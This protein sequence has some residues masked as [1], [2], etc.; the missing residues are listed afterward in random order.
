MLHQPGSPRSPAPVAGEPRRPGSPLAP[1]PGSPTGKCASAFTESVKHRAA[2]AV[3][4]A[5]G[6]LA[7]VLHAVEHSALAAKGA[8]RSAPGL[9]GCAN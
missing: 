3:G 5:T 6:R 1:E 7:G 2:E 4:A 9:A 8:R